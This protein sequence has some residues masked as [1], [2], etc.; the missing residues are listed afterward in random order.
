MSPSVSTRRRTRTGY[1]SW[2]PPRRCSPRMSWIP[3]PAIGEPTM[4]RRLILPAPTIRR[5]CAAERRCS[6]PSRGSSGSAR[7]RRR[8][9]RR[10]RSTREARAAMTFSPAR[11][12]FSRGAASSI[13][14]RRR[15]TPWTTGGCTRRG[16]RRTSAR[17]TTRGIRSV[18]PG[19]VPGVEHPRR[20]RLRP[21]RV[22]CGWAAGGATR[23]SIPSRGWIPWGV[24]AG[25]ACP[26]RRRRRSGR[27]RLTRRRRR[28]RGTC[29]RGIRSIPSG[30]WE[31][32][33]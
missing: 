4:T 9:A 21:R 15:G 23:T 33:R 18:C 10:R 28:K 19:G 32:R 20:R 2:F 1:W 16:W 12:I 5:V 6:N 31:R 25:W 30:C 24:W 29:C 13:P 11:L 22:R 26:R 17:R 8:G 3:A 14:S 27:R 7:R